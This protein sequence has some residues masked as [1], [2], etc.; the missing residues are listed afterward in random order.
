MWGRTRVRRFVDTNISRNADGA[1]GCARGRRI[2]QSCSAARPVSSAAR[3]SRPEV[4]RPP[5]S[6]KAVVPVPKNIYGVTK[7]AAEDCA[8]LFFQIARPAVHSFCASPDSFRKP[9]TTRPAAARTDDLNLKVNEY[10]HRRVDL[11]DAVDAH[12]LA[13]ERVPEIGFA[14]YVVSATSP[15]APGHLAQ[16]RTDAPGCGS[17]PVPRLRRAVS[18]SVAGGCCPGSIACTLNH[19]GR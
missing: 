17:R 11:A 8:S 4:S 14:R 16:L 5:G 6:T 12:I 3:S 2:R 10:L 18:S 19:S 9:T 13:A 7:K 15:F 1:R